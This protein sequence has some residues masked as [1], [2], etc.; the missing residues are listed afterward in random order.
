MKIICKVIDIKYEDRLKVFYSQLII[1]SCTTREFQKMFLNRILRDHPLSSASQHS[2]YTYSIPSR[3]FSLCAETAVKGNTTFISSGAKR[4]KDR[5]HW[6][7]WI[8]VNG[9]SDY[10]KARFPMQN[11]GDQRFRQIHV[12]AKSVCLA[13]YWKT[14]TSWVLVPFPGCTSPDTLSLTPI[15]V[16]TWSHWRLIHTTSPA[17]RSVLRCLNSLEHCGIRLAPERC[18]RAQ[19]WE[20]VYGMEKEA[21]PTNTFPNCCVLGLAATWNSTINLLL[22]LLVGI[23]CHCCKTSNPIASC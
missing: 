2:N 4:V 17:V 6:K 20:D 8:S 3:L 7:L 23:S 15:L 1:L 12:M 19:E 22:M 14:F 21:G 18:K 10:S 16:L 11:T 9:E 13:C 5:Q